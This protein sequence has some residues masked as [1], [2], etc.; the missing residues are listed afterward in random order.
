MSGGKV[1]TVT[2]SASW[3]TVM[4]MSSSVVPPTVTGTPLL[5]AVRNPAISARTSY[6]PGSRFTMRYRPSGSVVTFLTTPVSTFL[7]MT[8]TPGMT[9]PLLSRTLPARVPV[10]VWE[11]AGD[12][13][14]RQ[15]SNARQARV[16]NELLPAKQA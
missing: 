7:A 6:V 16:M 12:A 13:Q 1:A 14:V 15:A 9:A 11:A 10:D 3:P 8:A 5:I 4:V 2:S